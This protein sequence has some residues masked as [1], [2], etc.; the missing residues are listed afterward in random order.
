MK[1]AVLETRRAVAGGGAAGAQGAVQAAH[2]QRVR[3]GARAPRLTY[4]DSKNK[5]AISVYRFGV[6][7]ILRLIAKCGNW[8]IPGLSIAQLEAALNQLYHKNGYFGDQF[9]IGI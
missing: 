4:R 7:S 8:A 1:L 2:W 5:C 6:Q 3:R 9:S